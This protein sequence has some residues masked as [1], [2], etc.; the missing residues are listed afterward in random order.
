MTHK[1]YN[2]LISKQKIRCIDD[3]LY[4]KKMFV[5]PQ[6]SLNVINVGHGN[7]QMITITDKHF[8]LHYNNKITINSDCVKENE[9]LKLDPTK[10]LIIIDVIT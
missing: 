5:T 4:Y 2:L 9:T 7:N 1:N 6:K 10:K 8:L 3:S